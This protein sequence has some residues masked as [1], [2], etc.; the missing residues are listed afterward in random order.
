MKMKKLKKAIRKINWVHMFC[1]LGFAF[2]MTSVFTLVRTNKIISFIF[3]GTF[4]LIL[5]F[6]LNKEDIK[7]N[8]K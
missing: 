1:S 7:E 8:R 4:G 2:F 3:G 6:K 5:L